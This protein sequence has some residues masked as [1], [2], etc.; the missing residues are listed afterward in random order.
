MPVK[1]C[2]L[3]V[4]KR[5]ISHAYQYTPGNGFC[6]AYS[7]WSGDTIMILT[8]TEDLKLFNSFFVITPRGVFLM[9]KENIC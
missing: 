3:H 4:I 1:A 9:F 6:Y 7:L 2:E 5:G 8:G